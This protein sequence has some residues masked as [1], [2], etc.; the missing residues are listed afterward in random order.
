MDDLDLIKRWSLTDQDEELNLE[1]SYY[2]VEEAED[3]PPLPP[4][5]LDRDAWVQLRVRH[6]SLWD[7]QDFNFVRRLLMRMAGRGTGYIVKLY[8]YPDYFSGLSIW[9]PDGWAI[10]DFLTRQLWEGKSVKLFNPDWELF[11]GSGKEILEPYRNR[12]AM[13]KE[14]VITLKEWN[15]NVVSYYF[16]KILGYIPFVG[17]LDDL[18][19]VIL[20]VQWGPVWEYIMF[21][22][23]TPNIVIT[24]NWY[25]CKQQINNYFELYRTRGGS[26]TV[27]PSTKQPSYIVESPPS[28]PPPRRY[29][30]R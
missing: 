13:W 25:K 21:E 28:S 27:G 15:A 14:V 23:T 20:N 26:T 7:V 17:Y 4:R 10:D 12:N 3:A 16:Q 19:D 22:N 24:T 5:D 1:E 9:I 6:P 18:F 29:G 11:G 30:G 2:V 8:H